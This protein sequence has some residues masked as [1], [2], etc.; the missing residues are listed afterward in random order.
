VFGQACN[1]D[2]KFNKDVWY[3]YETAPDPGVG[4]VATTQGDIAPP[5]STTVRTQY[6]VV[7]HKKLGGLGV[8]GWSTSKGGTSTNLDDDVDGHIWDTHK[9]GTLKPGIWGYACRP[10]KGNPSKISTHSWGAAVD[11]N[12]AYEHFGPEH[13]HV[14]TIDDVVAGIFQDH[15]WNWGRNFCDSMHFQYATGY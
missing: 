8:Q 7:F 4:G 3:G 2:A 13:C 6:L 10:I 11:I 5:G 15:N 12:A 14:H 1:L 9:Q